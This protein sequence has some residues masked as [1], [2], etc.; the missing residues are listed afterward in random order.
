MSERRLWGKV[1]IVLGLAVGVPILLACNIKGCD[2]VPYNSN[3]PAARIREQGK[4]VPV[5][6]G[7]DYVRANLSLSSLIV[8]FFERE[9]KKSIRAYVKCRRLTDLDRDDRDYNYTLELQFALQKGGSTFHTLKRSGNFTGEVSL[10]ELC[11]EDISDIPDQ[12]V[13]TKIRV[14]RTAK[15][16]PKPVSQPTTRPGTE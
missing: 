4:T 8:D 3:S 16:R 14:M 15:P 2:E 7:D 12:I 5:V 9:G 10:N 6:A 11:K 13:V 1:F